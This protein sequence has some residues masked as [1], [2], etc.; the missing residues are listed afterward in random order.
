M[1]IPNQWAH[2]CQHL[3]PLADAEVLAAFRGK[4]VVRQ[5]AELLSDM[6]HISLRGLLLV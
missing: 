1:T 3:A 2:C 4:P 5:A 6:Q